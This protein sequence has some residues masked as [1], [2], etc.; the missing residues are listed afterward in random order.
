MFDLLITLLAIAYAYFAWRFILSPVFNADRLCQEDID[1]IAHHVDMVLANRAD[2]A[3]LDAYLRTIGGNDPTSSDDDSIT[4]DTNSITSD[5][6]SIT[7]DDDS[8]A[9]DDY[10]ANTHHDE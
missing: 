2:R 7:S 10:T 1:A 3:E 6:N 8:L 4:S 5:A 9:S